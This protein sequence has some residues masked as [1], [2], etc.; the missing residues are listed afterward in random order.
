MPERERPPIVHVV[1]WF[2]MIAFT[3]LFA[4]LGTEF[5]AWRRRGESWRTLFLW[6]IGIY[7][8]LLL[9]HTFT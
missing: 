5:L 1:L 4:G 6:Y 7:D 8:I 2:N 3:P 9:I